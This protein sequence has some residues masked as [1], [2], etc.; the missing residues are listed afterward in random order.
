V[1]AREWLSGLVDFQKDS[2]SEEFLESVKIDLFPDKVYVFTPR[3]DILRLPRGST[4]V[5]FA[6]A[7]HTD[8]G[9]RCVA[10]NVDRRRVPLRTTLTNGQTVS[11]NT[12]KDAYP[13]PAWLNF[14]VTAKARTAIRNYLKNLRTGEAVKLGNRLLDNALGEFETRLKKIPAE[15]MKLLLNNMGLAD[16][17]SLYEEIGLGHQLAPLIARRLM[18]SSDSIDHDQIADEEGPN[19]ELSIAGTEGMI[20]SFGRC[21]YPVPGDSVMGHLSAGRGLVVHR[22]QCGNLAEFRKQ[23]DKWINI[24][25]EDAIA[26]QFT[27][28]IQVEALDKVGVLASVATR[29]SDV[30][31]NIEHVEV[32][33]SDGGAS[34]LAFTI[35]VK[36]SDHLRQVMKQ[37][38]SMPDVLLVERVC[39]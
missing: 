30:G 3:G 9:N 16:R 11:I 22:Q 10:S 12:R 2:N 17:N 7:V 4:P 38:E 21:C 25:W 32:I 1:Q 5:D 34:R 20:V 37:I 33:D 39:A 31:S 27:V 6:Y 35:R 29:I 28:A 8:I 13:N 19:K 18:S 26:S 15:S 24:T 14:V 23:P 36:D